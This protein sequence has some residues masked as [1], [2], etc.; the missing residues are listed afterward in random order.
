MDISIIA[1]VSENGVIGREG[2][3]PWRLPDEL[4]KFKA[5]TMGHHL[6]LGRKTYESL[7]GS[8][9]GREILVVTRS[10]S[11]RAPGRQVFPGLQPAL[12]QAEASG[13]TEV[14]IG[15]GAQ[16][17]ALALPLAGRMYLTR[18]HATVEGDTCFPSF[19]ERLWEVSLAEYHPQDE[20]HPY[21]FTFTVLDRI[22]DRMLNSS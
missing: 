6:I 17:Y 10:R 7:P 18:V 20:R 22:P 9:P 15:G 21:A 19:D 16:I 1:A 12:D 13:E 2:D 8:L 4:R 5:L 11:Y 14:F 3:L